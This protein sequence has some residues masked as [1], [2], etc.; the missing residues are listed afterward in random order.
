MEHPTAAFWNI[1]L[2][3]LVIVI[4]LAL[5]QLRYPLHRR[6]PLVVYTWG[7]ILIFVT[8]LNWVRGTQEVSYTQSLGRYSLVLFPITILLADR[9]LRTSRRIRLLVIAGLAVG[10]AVFSTLHALGVGP[11]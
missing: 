10:L 1:D 7:S 4:A 9:L 3:M 8:K 2:W 11:A 6:L 5:V